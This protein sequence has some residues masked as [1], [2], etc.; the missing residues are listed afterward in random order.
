MGNICIEPTAGLYHLWQSPRSPPER[1]GETQS[2][3]QR[4]NL[5]MIQINLA[6][7]ATPIHDR[8]SAREIKS[9]AE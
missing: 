2:A 6:D 3:G 7:K 9:V 4:Q 5:Q 1:Y 8:I